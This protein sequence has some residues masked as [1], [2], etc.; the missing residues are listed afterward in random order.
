MLR[1][2]LVEA[3]CRKSLRLHVEIAKETGSGKAGSMMSLE[4]DKILLRAVNCYDPLSAV[5][6][7]GLLWCFFTS[8]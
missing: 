4:T 6:I 1:G 5:I 3:I 8:K 7:L 2:F